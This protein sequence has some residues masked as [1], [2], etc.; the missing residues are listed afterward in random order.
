M[1][2]YGTAKIFFQQNIYLNK[3]KSKGLM[4]MRG[5]DVKRRIRDARDALRNKHQKI[6]DAMIEKA[7]MTAVAMIFIVAILAIELAI[8]SLCVAICGRW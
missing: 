8:W 5:K 2:S 1:I 6:I 3:D 7:R 4:E